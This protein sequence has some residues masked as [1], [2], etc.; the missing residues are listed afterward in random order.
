MPWIAVCSTPA[1]QPRVALALAAYGYE[2][3]VPTETFWKHFRGGEKHKAAAPLFS[4][5]TFAR[6]EPDRIAELLAIEGVRDVLRSA[7]GNRP[8]PIPDAVID[9]LRG[10]AE[11]RLFDRAR[12]ATL[13][14]G[15]SVR[16]TSGPLA[17]LVGKIKSASPK[18]R[19]KL[20][21]SFLGQLTEVDL[22]VDKLEKF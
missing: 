10:A 9:G 21:I 6:A 1:A 22:P 15:T 12:P 7:A 13:P 14:A 11:A 2:A 19:A 8:Q 18:H 5:Y 17:G 4:G 16:L 20:L 3:F